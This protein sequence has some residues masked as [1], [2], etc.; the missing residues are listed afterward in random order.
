MWKS[1]DDKIYYENQLKNEGYCT[2]HKKPVWKS[3]DD[4][5]YFEN[6]LKNEGY[7]TFKQVGYNFNS[8]NFAFNIIFLSF[9]GNC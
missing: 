3:K 7:C 6:Q 8:L 4:K 1:K 9:K 2:F 5:I